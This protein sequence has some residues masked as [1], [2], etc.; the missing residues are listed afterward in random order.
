MKKESPYDAE[1]KKLEEEEDRIGSELRE[2]EDKRANFLCPFKV[3]DSIINRKNKKAVVVRIYASYSDYAM[4][5]SMIRK[6]GTQGRIARAYDWD[7]WE[8]EKK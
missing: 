1:I 7:N 3:G 6:D 2:A 8:K 4:N 5:I